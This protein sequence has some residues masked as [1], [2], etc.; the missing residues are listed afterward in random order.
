MNSGHTASKSLLRTTL[1]Q[2]PLNK[3]RSAWC[4]HTVA[5]KV[6]GLDAH[7]ATGSN[8]GFLQVISQSC[9]TGLT[10]HQLGQLGEVTEPRQTPVLFSRKQII[11]AKQ[12][13]EG[14]CEKLNNTCEA[15]STGLAQRESTTRF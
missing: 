2:S 13:P 4:A 6:K 5:V 7:D 8:V 1:P 12:L 14:G 9:P 11:T 3:R 10:S 15:L